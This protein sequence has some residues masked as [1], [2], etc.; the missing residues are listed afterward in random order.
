MQYHALVIIY[1]KRAKI[2]KRYNQYGKVTKH[3]KTLQARELRG[4]PFPS[5]WP[6]GCTELTRQYN[7]EKHETQITKKDLQKKYRLG[8]VSQK[9]LEGLNMFNG[10]KLALNS[11]VDQ[12]T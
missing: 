8:M 3:K 2:R 1:A 9:I 6:Q 11:D 7:K 5:R 12:D 4:Q 10:T